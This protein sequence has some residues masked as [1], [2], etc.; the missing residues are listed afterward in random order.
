MTTE[1]AKKILSFYRPGTADQRDPDFAEAL[2][3]V[4]RSTGNSARPEER[5]PELA[6]WFEEHCASY[7]TGHLKFGEIAVPP[8][9]KEQI[10]AERKIVP[11]RVEKKTA[12]LALAAGIVA[13]LCFSA[14]FLRRGQTMSDFTDCRNQMVRMALSPYSMDLET[15]N[16]E[17]VRSYL[18]ERNAPANYQLPPRLA[19]AQIAGSAVKSWDNA[20]VS[21]ICFRTG[22]PL[23]AGDT[24]DL[25]L[26]IIDDSALHDAPN[27]TA[28]VFAQV[29]RGM[30]ASWTRD[31][32]TYILVGN[33]D[34]MSLEQYL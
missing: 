24:T 31:H 33:R 8:G 27:S 7:K 20:A 34:K 13:L 4:R 10:L 28:P 5:N 18:A 29:S 9:F 14:L 2:E 32:L 1:D 15:T 3:A 6:K 23:R 11:L 21:M 25:W 17:Q 16:Q 26:F 22:R 12:W 30:T 19:G